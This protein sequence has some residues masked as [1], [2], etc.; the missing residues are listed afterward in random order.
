VDQRTSIIIMVVAAVIV[1]AAI[2]VTLI[3]R[4]RSLYLKEHFG[5][6]YDRALR[7]RGDRTKA[8]LELINREKRVHAFTIKPLL[9]AARERYLG[10]WHTVQARFVDDP[11][12]AVNSA[13]S[14]VN[15]V[16]TEQGYPMADFEQRAADISVTHPI[17][18]Q[19]YRSARAIMIRYERNEAD[20]EDLRKAMVYYR[21]L[22]DE[23]LDLPK[24]SSIDKGVPYERAS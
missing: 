6:E 19:N 1:L 18:V 5:P 16:M 7:Q 11:V 13:D 15:R 9:P 8:E 22:F 24:T 10:E 2:V 3:R 14:L 21:T 20:T 12:V 4:R 17:V 23:L